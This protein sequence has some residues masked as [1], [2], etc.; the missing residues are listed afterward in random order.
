[1]KRRHRL[2]AA[3]L[4]AFLMGVLSSVASEDAPPASETPDPLA[5]LGHEV[6]SGAA[7]GYVDSKLCGLCHQD[8]YLSY[9]E[10]GMARSFVSPATA[11]A[12]GRWIEDFDAA[13]F[14]HEASRRYYR[15]ERGESGGLR[16][17]RWQLDAEGRPIHEIELPVDWVLG[18]GNHSRVYL[19]RT[20]MGELYQLPLAWYSQA[21]GRWAMSPG[22]DRSD[23]EGVVRRVRR[24]CM[25]CHNGYP[26]VPEGSDAY[27]E[28][29]T[30]PAELPEGTG[31]Q[32]CHG[33]GAEHV[34]RALSREAT[35]EAVRAAIANPGRLEPRL[36]NG[37][38]YEC[39][40]QPSVA[41]P[42]V[43]RFGRG[44]YSFRP[45]EDLA[46]YRVGIDVREA[47]RD[48]GD[49]FEINHHPYRLEQ[50][51][52]FRESAGALSCLTCHDPH[53]KV[54]PAERAAHYRAAC[55]GCHEDGLSDHP[56]L[57]PPATLAASDC[58]A[59]HMPERR[60][61]DVVHVV[62]TDHR[63]QRPP[64]DPAA[65]LA[66]REEDHDPQ[67]VGLVLTEPGRAPAGALGEVYRAA[68]AVRMGASLETAVPHLEKNLAAAAPEEAAPWLDLAQ[69]QLGLQKWADA[70]ATLGRVLAR[71]PGH[72][73]A[74]EWLAIALA[75]QG[76]P[77]DATRVLRELLAE[78]P[79]RPEPRFNLA[80]LLLDRDGAAEEAAEHLRRVLELR[81]NQVAAWQYLGA[82]YLALDRPAEAADAL[83]QAL[84]LDP[85]RTEAYL[86]L[87][88]ALVALDRR[89]E[90]RRYLRHGVREA[91]RPEKLQSRLVELEP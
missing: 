28:P 27:G 9:Q 23:H 55:L 56:L 87:A 24:E 51:A 62:M 5:A 53:R 31:C 16:F 25:F 57:P 67:I 75:G 90:A 74:R 76:R 86:R 50:S 20:P 83:R 64:E 47:G 44:D 88:D 15:I 3:G 13:P 71:T 4:L 32:R 79:D 78:D 1:M 11:H 61:E 22:F 34:R 43:R 48:P 68:A 30:F 19:Y 84:A 85:A 14:F 54:P 81:P 12:Q 82:A 69:G 63:I 6:T 65:L 2:A 52:C 89:D 77:D 58:T 35:A 41:I 80:R 8:E 7:P 60:T 70:E 39:H 10:V 46:E 42:G 73:L 72:A 45:G 38:C 21:G 40:M 33:P 29:Q 37:V 91:T 59:C 17:R 49:R 26:D 36:R 66:P 18:S